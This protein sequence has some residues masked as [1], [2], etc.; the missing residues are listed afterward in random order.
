MIAGLE[1]YVCGRTLCQLS[2]STQRVRLCVWHACFRVISEANDFAGF[3]HDDT[4]HT[5]VGVGA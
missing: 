3:R 5:G 1:C 2:C 4:P